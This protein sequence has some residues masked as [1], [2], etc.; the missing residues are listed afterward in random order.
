MKI[1]YLHGISYLEI[2]WWKGRR[3]E[4]SFEVGKISVFIFILK[5]PLKDCSLLIKST[6]N[7]KY[8]KVRY[9]YE[10]ALLIR[11]MS[12]YAVFIVYGVTG[13]CLSRYGEFFGYIWFGKNHCIQNMCFYMRFFIDIQNRRPSLTILTII[14]WVVRQNSLSR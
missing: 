13:Q 5:A 4:N 9:Y 1:V 8:S 3:L 7:L 14:C 12:K 2:V 6:L 11:K 10:V